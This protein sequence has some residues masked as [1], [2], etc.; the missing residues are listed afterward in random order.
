MRVNV[1]FDLCESNAVC[2]GIEPSVFEVDEDDF[3]DVL[4]E[5]PPENLR[6]TVEQAARMCPMQAITIEG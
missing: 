3:L 4:Q 2:M 5:E 1:N 6:P